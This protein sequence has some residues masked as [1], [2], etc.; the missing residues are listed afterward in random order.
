MTPLTFTALGTQWWIELFDNIPAQRHQ[1]ISDDIVA[2]LQS[3]EGR[4][5][6]FLPN[7]LVSQLNTARALHT[8]DA[9]LQ[10][11]LT[12]G[13]KLYTDTQ[14]IFNILLG[15]HLSARGYN[16][17]YSF[18]ATVA[19]KKIANPSI[20]LEING[21]TITLHHGSIDLGGIGKGWAID[22]IAELLHR[23]HVHE[24]LINGGGD[25][26]GTT[27]HGN[28]IEIYLEHP[29]VPGTFL[30]TTAICNQGFAASS[31]H[32]RKWK[33]NDVTYTH[34]VGIHEPTVD[35]SFVIA[36]TALLAD[37]YATASLLS[38]Y[39]TTHALLESVSAAIARYHISTQKLERSDLF[40]FTPL[41]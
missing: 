26:Y 18:Q 25:L 10:E 24:F 33:S 16:A 29:T 11:L 39:E 41:V 21:N 13:Q 30:G 36:P 2:L 17:D 31:P 12:T 35:A 27:E 40:H 32:K 4:F 5:S 1:V 22:K 3:I 15:D 19:P 8:A 14:G 6:R 38:S 9:D 20:D 7:S 34:I 23:H 28:P 37:V